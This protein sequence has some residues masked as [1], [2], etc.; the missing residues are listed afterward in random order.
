MSKEGV[1][2]ATRHFENSPAFSGLLSPASPPKLMSGSAAP[3]R[4]ARLYDL[5]AFHSELDR[6][7]EAAEDLYALAR[8]VRWAFA[9]EGGTALLIY[10]VWHLWQILK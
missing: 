5:G 9:I 2:L 8:G 1:K 4:L 6:H 10:A 3:L 7:R